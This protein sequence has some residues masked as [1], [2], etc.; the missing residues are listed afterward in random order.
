MKW[1][2]EAPANIALIKYMGKSEKNIPLN[3]SLS[4]TLKRFL[5]TVEIE[6]SNPE[7]GGDSW[8]PL[9]AELKLSESDQQKFLKHLKF[10][11]STAN[12][13][14]T[15]T[16]RSK[17][18]FPSH[19]GLASSAS[20]FAALTMV[21]FKA[22]KD[23]K[24]TPLAPIE[25]QAE[26]SRQGSGSS[27]RSFFSPWALWNSK[28]CGRIELPI[29]ELFHQV[30]VVDGTPKKVSSSDAHKKV[31]TSGLWSGRPE[32]AEERLKRLLAAF[33]A[34]DWRECYQVV[35]EEF[36]DMHSLFHTSQPHFSYMSKESLRHLQLLRDFWEGEG[37]GPLVTMDAGPNIHLLY[38]K[39][40]RELSQKIRKSILENNQIL[41]DWIE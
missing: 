39:D 20:S 23:L 29:G 12:V 32:R 37:D 35:W 27:C 33:R 30:V 4:F 38:R 41:G 11:K 1:T 7:V 34:E 40:Q 28:T 36:W 21:A 2:A 5:T 10:L 13:E 3:S 9:D 31:M 16:V 24:N 15:F 19:C 6:T 17:N 25:L 14:E 18:N 22:F 8:A 26:W